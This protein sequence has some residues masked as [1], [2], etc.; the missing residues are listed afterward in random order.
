MGDTAGWGLLLAV[1]GG[2]GLGVAAAVLMLYFASDELRWARFLD[3]AGSLFDNRL[4]RPVMES[5]L[6]R[7]INRKT[8]MGYIRAGRFDKAGDIAVRE[9]L[10][11]ESVAMLEASGRIRE[12]AKLARRMG[13][14]ADAERLYRSFMA[15]CLEKDMKLAAAETAE[16]AGFWEDA[17]NLYRGLEGKESRLKAARISAAHG[18]PGL[19]I[20]I[21]LSEEA[22]LDAMRTAEEAGMLDFLLQFCSNSPNAVLH[23]FGADAA[24]RAGKIGAAI[25]ILE[26]HGHLQNAAAMAREAGLAEKAAALLERIREKRLGAPKETSK[27]GGLFAFDFS[28]DA[29]EEGK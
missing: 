21:F 6:G 14:D 12:A 7:W 25:G 17:V 4:T 3:T 24:R 27:S 5:G 18:L 15:M 8:I 23:H 9:A 13:R 26:A 22:L 16:E 28:D 10:V 11:D 19:A 20:E 2:G 1:F 29:L